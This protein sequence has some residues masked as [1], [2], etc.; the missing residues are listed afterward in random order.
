MVC[1]AKRTILGLIAIAWLSVSF[2]QSNPY[3][4]VK[5]F[6][7][8]N[9]LT[10]WL[11][12]DHSQPEI[13]GAVIVKAGG[14]NDPADATGIAHYFEHM[15]F[16]G[17]DRI[18]TIDWEKEKVYLDS[19]SLLYDSLA[20]TIEED[21]RRAIQKHINKLSIEAANFAIP[22]ETDIILQNIGST[23]L[24]AYTSEEETVYFNLF[25]SNQVEK[26][27]EI[28][29]ERFRNPVFRLFQSE[30]ETVYEEKN[31]YADDPFS[32]LFEDFMRNF[33]KNHPYGQQTILGTTEHLKNPRLSKMM[34]FFRTYYVANNMALI[35]SGNF[36]I[37]EVLPMIKEKFSILPQKPIPD[38]PIYEEKPFKGRE[39]IIKKM[40]PIAIGLI[41]YRA[42]PNNHPDL[43]PL[44]LAAQILSNNGSTGMLDQLNNENKLLSSQAF[45]LP[46]N[47]HGAVLVLFVPKVVG[48]KL[49]TAENLVLAQIERLK[50]GDF[51]D[52]LL[53]GIKLNYR[54]SIE[55]QLES[56]RGRVMLMIQAFSQ[57]KSWEDILN[58][59][60]RVDLI[61]KEDIIR[62]A[63]RYFTG[64]YLAYH[65]KMGFPKKE[66]IK[67]PDWDPVMPKNTE[68][69][70][71][72]AH[73]VDELP[74][75]EISPKF[76]D[77]AKDL[78]YDTL[79]KGLYFYQTNNPYNS[80]FSLRINYLVGTAKNK[81]YQYALSYMD[82]I[83]T[84]KK[85]HAQFKAELQK[86]GASVSFYSGENS[87]TIY[88]EG[89]DSK[90]EETLALLSELLANPELNERPI[91]KFVQENKANYKSTIKN[92]ESLGDALAEYGMYK[93]KSDYL[94]KLSEKDIKKL[95]PSHLV[96]LLNEIMNYEAEI[97]YVGTLQP[98]K[99]KNAVTKHLNFSN[100]PKK[101]Q[102]EEKYL[103]PITS[104][105]IYI[106]HYPKAIQSKIYLFCE[107]EIADNK[108]R[109]LLRGFN[110]YFGAGMSS[111]VFQ[112][113]REFRSLGY[114]AYAFY[115]TPTLQDQKGFLYSYLGTQNDKAL[116][117][118][119]A[120]YQLIAQ[121]P[122]KPDRINFI[123]RGLMQSVHT[124]NP[125][126]R[127]LSTT[128]SRWKKMGYQED[129][130][131]N[132][133]KIFETMSF[134]DIVNTYE[135]F[136]K[137]KPI[138]I[139]IV[140]DFK[141]IDKKALEK[142]GKI[143][144]LKLPEFIKK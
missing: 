123:K 108:D 95:K 52:E 137:N 73:M 25:P 58:L 125:N 67:K 138:S 38:Y 79:Q 60:T 56:N 45:A 32:N 70:S 23:A 69:K 84:N 26:W 103:N 91:K 122:I 31:M 37:E 28:Y 124:Q 100:E 62:V 106:Y 1:F 128:V 143:S 90:L 22:N 134:D 101:R 104:P 20:I 93:E 17:T 27:L 21:R 18:G 75:V 15:M 46:Q 96:Q 66:K 55:K 88:V 19:I 89:F 133:M 39:Q 8:D 49:S 142:Y 71:D 136:I 12:E 68:M 57:G 116:E 131:I 54:K 97:H 3:L 121:M 127:T 112:E 135:K 29:A 4:E 34:E 110:E 102:F 41:G 51:S 80:I 92:P 118:T 42:V 144:E 47:D 40:T 94:D 141:I 33:Y 9:G 72:F 78:L 132:Q 107:G 140:G 119:D 113:I 36:N 120:M 109:A 30:L 139:T 105:T 130:R 74:E 10:V 65:S 82:N 61:T 77:F 111:I 81:E 5:K 7:L 87:S 129:P 13:F 126:F 63:N 48:Q 86:L 83:G 14:K 98:D 64:N 115:S 11:N 6:T 35:M 59:S 76:I 50:S 99:V 53:E 85:S 44:T 16:K 2:T 24:N 114:A 43:L 117:G